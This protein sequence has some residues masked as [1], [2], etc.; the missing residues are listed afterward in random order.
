MY[1]D[2]VSLSDFTSRKVYAC[3]T[4]DMNSQL[5]VSDVHQTYCMC[6]AQPLQ[7]KS[8][9]EGGSGEPTKSSL[10]LNLCTLYGVDFGASTLA[11]LV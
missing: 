8:V 4:W 3:S 5:C 7:C 2:F 10:G 9:L 11:H 6:M 1:D